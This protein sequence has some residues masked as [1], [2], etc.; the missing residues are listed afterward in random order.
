MD[1]PPFCFVHAPDRFCVTDRYFRARMIDRSTSRLE[2][3][4][5]ADAVAGAEAARTDSSSARDDFMRHPEL[6]TQD[7]IRGTQSPIRTLWCRLHVTR[8]TGPG[9][10]VSKKQPPDPPSGVSGPACPGDIPSGTP[11]DAAA[12]GDQPASRGLANTSSAAVSI[13]RSVGADGQ[14]CWSGRDVAGFCAWPLL[15]DRCCESRIP[16]CQV[17]FKAVRN[18]SI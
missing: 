3:S 17:R 5:W 6:Q 15:R 12:A 7:Q 1:S 9:L 14:D 8:L 10:Q 11:D 4:D 13:S 18:G 16:G 2:G